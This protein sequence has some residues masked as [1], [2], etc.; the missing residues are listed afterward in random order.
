MSGI[1][2]VAAATVVLAPLAAAAL[3]VAGT[4]AIAAGTAKLIADL[5]GRPDIADQVPSSYSGTYAKVIDQV[6]G[7]KQPVAEKFLDVVEGLL[8][9]SGGGK[10]TFGKMTDELVERID[11]SND[12]A[13]LAVTID[14]SAEN[15]AAENRPKSQ[16]SQPASSNVM[17][18]VN[19]I[20]SDT[21]A[22]PAGDTTTVAPEPEK[23]QK[24]VKSSTAPQSKGPMKVHPNVKG[25]NRLGAHLKRMFKK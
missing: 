7:N 21:L 11:F 14:Q 15:A 4:F 24:P 12:V 25:L 9:P 10:P 22:H 6:A 5:G 8:L 17:Q 1:I 18:E 20:R 2:A 19:T 23:E 3:V 16:S 13:E